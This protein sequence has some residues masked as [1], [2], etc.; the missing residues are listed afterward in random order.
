[1]NRAGIRPIRSYS[2]CLAQASATFRPNGVAVAELI[3]AEPQGKGSEM[4]SFRNDLEI[5]GM[6][7]RWVIF[8]TLWT[9]LSGPI[10]A[11]PGKASS[12]P[13]VIHPI[14]VDNPKK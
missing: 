7:F 4:V 12:R 1:V 14:K 11:P 3:P 13:G 10:F 5:A 6:Q 9:M 8:I 2:E